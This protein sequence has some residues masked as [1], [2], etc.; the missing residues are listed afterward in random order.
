MENEIYN[1]Y[2]VRVMRYTFQTMKNTLLGAFKN[3]ISTWAANKGS[4]IWELVPLSGKNFFC[5]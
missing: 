5:I 3:L 2:K 1:M 4:E